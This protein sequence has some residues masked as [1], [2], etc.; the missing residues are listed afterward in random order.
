[1]SEQDRLEA[2]NAELADRDAYEQQRDY[3]ETCVI[4][5]APLLIR[6]GAIAEFTCGCIEDACCGVLKG[7]E[8]P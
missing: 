8:Q 6:T 2:Y 5:N 3:Y 7:C 4:C 1:V